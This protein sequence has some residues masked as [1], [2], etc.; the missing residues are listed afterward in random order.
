MQMM[1]S[2]NQKVSLNQGDFPVFCTNTK[3]YFLAEDVQKFTFLEAAAQAFVFFAAGFETSSTTMQFALYELSL[4]PEI[5]EKT[6]EEILKVLEKHDGKITYESIYEMNYLG[7]VIDETL[8]KYP[9]VPVLQR[10]CTKDF[11]IPDTK[12]VIPAGMQVQVPI[13]GMHMDPEHFPNPG[14][15][16]PDR[17]TEE[18][19]SK[20]HHYAYLPF[21][22]G[23]RNCIGKCE[24]NLNKMKKEEKKIKIF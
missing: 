22:E 2:K 14:K 4:N 19:K 8:R 12:V 11:T 21:G 1:V 10:E 23:P 7:R 16:D 15:F 9:A 6:R 3:Q 17:F 18:E 24:K 20:R 13:Y 5:Q